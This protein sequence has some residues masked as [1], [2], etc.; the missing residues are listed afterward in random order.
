M[1][2]SKELGIKAS[3]ITKPTKLVLDELKKKGG[4]FLC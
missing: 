3:M 4:I 1:M 2:S